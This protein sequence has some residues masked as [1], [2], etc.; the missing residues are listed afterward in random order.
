[1]NHG[2]GWRWACALAMLVVTGAQA[3]VRVALVAAERSD[4]A[5]AIMDLAT[6]GMSGESGV[7]MIERQN[8]DTLLAEQEWSLAGIVGAADAVRAGRLLE[9]DILVVLQQPAPEKPPAVVAFDSST[10]IRL[11]DEE[12]PSE[13][14]EAQAARVAEL[15]RQAVRKRGNPDHSTRTLS[16]LAVQDV[17]LPTQQE[18]LAGAIG[19]LLER[20][21]IRSP[22]VTILERERLETLNAERTLHAGSM[23]NGLWTSVYLLEMDIGRGEQEDEI[24]VYARITDPAGNPQ[25]EFVKTGPASAQDLVDSIQNELVRLLEM[26]PPP[27]APAREVE[28][29]RYRREAEL[30]FQQKQY[31]LAVRAAEA[32][33]ALNPEDL[34]ILSNLTRCHFEYAETLYKEK[35][36]QYLLKQTHWLDLLKSKY[37]DTSQVG[38][39]GPFL[40]FRCPSVN[41]AK[42]RG[43][44][45]MPS[46]VEYI[47][48]LR[49]LQN[50]YARHLGLSGTGVEDEK[51]GDTPLFRMLDPRWAFEE[52]AMASPDRD[53]YIETL[54]VY[55]RWWMKDVQRQPDSFQDFRLSEAM[56]AMREMTLYLNVDDHS[57]FI[58]DAPYYDGMHALFEEMSAHPVPYMSLYGRLGVLNCDLKTEKINPSEVIGQVKLMDQEVRARISNNVEGEENLRGLLYLFLLDLYDQVADLNERQLLYQG[59]FDFMLEQKTLVPAVGHAATVPYAG[60][61]LCGIIHDQQSLS[62]NH[63]PRLIRNAERYLEVIQNRDRYYVYPTGEWIRC[64]SETTEKS[65]RFMR[66]TLGLSPGDH[67]WSDA[68]LVMDLKAVA[69]ELTRIDQIHVE[70]DELYILMSSLGY[71]TNQAVALFKSDRHGQTV[72]CIFHMAFDWHDYD[73]KRLGVVCRYNKNTYIPTYGAGVLVVSDEGSHHWLNKESGLPSDQV[74]S[75]AVLDGSLYIASGEEGREA[76]LSRYDLGTEQWTLLAAANRREKIGPLDQ[77]PPYVIR[78][79]YA[80][81][82]RSRMVFA[83]DFEEFFMRQRVVRNEPAMSEL[84][85]WSYGPKN[86]SFTQLLPLNR[87]PSWTQAQGERVFSAPWNHN[88]YADG[89]YNQRYGLVVFDFKADRGGIVYYS[90]K[91]SPGP[92]LT[93]TDAALYVPAQLQEPPYAV[94]RDGVWFA[95]PSF[96]RHLFSGEV[97]FFPDAFSNQEQA[98]RVN[99]LAIGSDGTTLVVATDT[100]VWMFKRDPSVAMRDEDWEQYI[101]R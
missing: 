67:P 30:Q 19:Y 29:E 17:D 78:G 28:A 42:H 61:R 98:K 59:L 74:Q 89:E 95:R 92:D 64:E 54:S 6:A 7:Q 34:N 11:V 75:V 62:A 31:P 3:G 55:V 56:R 32:A 24:R 1:M 90:E 14:L 81:P 69:P 49:K 20:Q 91:N 9:A 77:V 13:N 27:E 100:Q 50:E 70:D 25:G 57:W 40:N 44:S 43:W 76:F 84:G 33:Y 58:R 2:H 52:V 21:L 53:T 26:A 12:L 80:D 16:V 96:G 60:Y 88:S 10:G 36:A 85:L 37:G 87:S 97:Q 5:S 48:L 47:E 39:L 38:F 79:M 35:G 45:P 4:H 15:C 99:H 83:V 66:E 72:H 86:E 22:T 8:I 73:P 63:F 23:E 46:Q 51:A 18:Y 101:S 71:I 41:P 93:P 68:V 82:G 65:L 94:Q